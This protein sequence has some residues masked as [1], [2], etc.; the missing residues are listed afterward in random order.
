MS[1]IDLALVARRFWLFSSFKCKACPTKLESFFR[2]RSFL[3]LVLSITYWKDF[4]LRGGS[5]VARKT[6]IIFCSIS[7]VMP[8]FPDK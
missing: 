5:W 3:E 2:R 4:R 8:G 7:L 1:P 6:V